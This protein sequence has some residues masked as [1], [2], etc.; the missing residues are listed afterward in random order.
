MV[1]SNDKKS[2]DLH[3]PR[4]RVIGSIVDE[5]QGPFIIFIL[6]YKDLTVALSS[7]D[8]ISWNKPLTV[9]TGPKISSTRVTDLGSL[10]RMTVGWI[11]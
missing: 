5:V 4:E 2:W 9:T 11:K 6:V 1:K 3:G 8:E 7:Q 10:L